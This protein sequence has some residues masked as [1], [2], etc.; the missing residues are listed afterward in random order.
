MFGR[1][2]FYCGRADVFR[3]QGFQKRT[4]AVQSMQSKPCGG[5]C[6]F[7]GHSTASGNQN[8]LLA[9]RK[10]NYSSVQAHA[11]AACLL[12]GVFPTPANDESACRS[13]ATGINRRVWGDVEIISGLGR[14]AGQTE[15]RLWGGGLFQEALPARERCEEP[16]L[17]CEAGPVYAAFEARAGAIWRKASTN[18]SVSGC[19][20]TVMRRKFG[21]E[22]N[23]RPTRIFRALN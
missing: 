23:R 13:G 15:N 21:I 22:A 1:V 8:G 19:V 20:P 7:R 17:F 14:I 11:G 4:Q 12:P 6:F 3:R 2:C 16:F 9:V 10:R 5:R 18:A